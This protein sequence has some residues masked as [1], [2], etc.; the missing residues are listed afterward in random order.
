[1]EDERDRIRKRQREGI[2]SA[3]ANAV[4]FGRPSI[5]ITD[6]FKLLKS[7]NPEGIIA[8]RAR[9]EASMRKTSFYKM[10]KEYEALVSTF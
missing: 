8:V 7:G 3:H 2:D 10:V 6:E 4:N 5:K 9:E 1:M